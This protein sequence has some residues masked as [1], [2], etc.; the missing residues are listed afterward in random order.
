MQIRKDEYILRSFSKLI[1]KK[2]ELYVITRIIHLLNDPEIEFV[3]QQPIRSKDDNRFLTDLC[4][5]GLK[6]YCEIDEKHHANEENSNA[7]ISR[8]KEILDATGFEE[9]RIAVYDE[10]KNDRD[11][12]DID[13]EID[14]FIDLI[15]QRKKDFLS[16]DKFFPW[17]YEKKLKPDYYIKKGYL[18][19]DENARFKYHKDALSLF[20]YKGGLYQRGT[21][22]IPDT[23][24]TVW[25]PKF[26][27]NKDWIN[28][29]SDDGKKISMKKIDY[30]KIENKEQWFPIVFPHYK[31][32]L[33]KFFY[34][35]MGEFKLSLEDSDD[36]E[37]IFLR[38]NTKIDL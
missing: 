18:D 27:E 1:N 9:M 22:N 16:E 6:L 24:K 19:V 29:L 14:N 35:F 26:Y 8:E 23:N 15:K 25:F 36:F 5:P 13:D 7:D 3:C 38:T 28:T 17:D 21:W 2:W 12:K 34:K 11:L 33:G 10:N 30:S 31:D 4:F 37:H 32:S 20:G